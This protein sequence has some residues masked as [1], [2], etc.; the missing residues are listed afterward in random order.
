MVALDCQ[1]DTGATYNVITHHDMCTIQQ[2]GN[3]VLQPTST[4]LKFYDGSLV[5]ALGEYKAHC[6][7]GGKPYNLDFKVIHGDQRPLLS[8]KTCQALGMI[9]IDT[10]N[11]TQPMDMIDQYKD[12]FEGLGCVEGDYHIEFDSS[13][14]PVQH[15]PRR[16]PVALKEQLKVKLDSFVSQGIITPVTPQHLGLAI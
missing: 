8:G 16:V 4:K 14:S 5:I 15:V 3:P 12:V 10:V 9:K 6:V 11:T 13:V 1:L 7:Y 2:N